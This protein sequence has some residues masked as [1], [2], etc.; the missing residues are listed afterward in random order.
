[1][2]PR[3]LKG[4]LIKQRPRQTCWRKG[5]VYLVYQLKCLLQDV[6]FDLFELF[7]RGLQSVSVIQ[8]DAALLGQFLVLE[9]GK[10]VMARLDLQAYRAHLLLFLCQQ[11]HASLIDLLGQLL[12][13]VFDLVQTMQR[14]LD[15][16]LL[17]VVLRVGLA[18]LRSF[19][20]DPRV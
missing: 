4:H 6:D 7:Y 10:T 18:E 1:M 17:E 14:V 9:S 16:L 13:S 5:R 3:S 8:H 11:I 2:L 12:F 19:V 15:V 20:R